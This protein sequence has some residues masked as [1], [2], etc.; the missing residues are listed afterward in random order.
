MPNEMDPDLKKLINFLNDLN[1]KEPYGLRKDVPCH[2][3]KKIQ[4]DLK[5]T[6]GED[7][8]E[9]DFE[10]AEYSAERLTTEPLNK[11]KLVI[12]HAL[13]RYYRIEDYFDAY[14]KKPDVKVFMSGGACKKKLN[15]LGISLVNSKFGIPP[16]KRRF[17]KTPQEVDHF[18]NQIKP[19]QVADLFEYAYQKN[20]YFGDLINFLRIAS[21]RY[22]G[23][24]LRL[25]NKSYNEYIQEKNSNAAFQFFLS[26]K[27]HLK[28]L[29]CQSDSPAPLTK[30]EMPLNAQP[31][32]VLGRHFFEKSIPSGT[33]KM[34]IQEDGKKG[35][36][37]ND[38][39][40]ESFAFS[41]N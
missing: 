20:M 1:K 12:A 8:E 18:L 3:L 29:N 14:S 6:F 40:F 11:I 39:F 34:K 4:K 38:Y 17:A 27:S 9:K 15:N 22:R 16:A 7:A 19:N 13:S 30:V 41:K 5:E 32:S 37:K 2:V 24:C 25:G 23:D 35:D 28:H 10:L 26:D 33:K 31:S 21:C 36:L